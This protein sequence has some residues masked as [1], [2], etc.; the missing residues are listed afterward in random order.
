MTH[1]QWV[2][3]ELKREIRKYFDVHENKDT[4]YQ[5]LWDAT[6]AVIR[7]KFVVVNAHFKKEERSRINSQIFLLK[8]LEKE[9]KI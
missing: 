5:N 2:K 7:R 3:E 4:I 6:K 1:N 8:T 9:D